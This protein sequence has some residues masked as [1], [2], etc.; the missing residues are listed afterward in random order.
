MNPE[1]HHHPLESQGFPVEFQTT[2]L[3]YPVSLNAERANH[4]AER[5]PDL[6][7]A[8]PERIGE[9]IISRRLKGDI[10]WKREA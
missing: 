4:I 3:Y 2:H 8:R 9:V 1:R 5:H 10:L 6:W 7:Y